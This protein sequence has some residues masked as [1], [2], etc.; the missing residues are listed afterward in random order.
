[1]VHLKSPEQIE[2]LRESSLLVGKTLAEVAK[3]M[4]PGVTTQ[5]LDSIAEEFIRDH[6]AVPGFKGY[7]GFPATLCVSVN[8][9]VV[10]GI[11]S[12]RVIKNGD[13]ISVDCGVIKNKYYGD[14][15]YTFPVGEVDENV[16][17]L[18]EVTKASLYEGIEAAIAGN[19]IGDIGYAIQSYV[20][21]H[22]FSVVRELV[23]HGLGK[24]LHEKPEVMNYGRRGNGMKLKEGLVICIEPMI[25]LGGRQVFQEADGWTVRT[26]D[27][28]PSAHYEHAIAVKKDKADILST[29]KYIEE[30]L[31][32]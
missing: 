2:L 5:K 31:N 24:K 17:K 10:H 27:R 4:K 20:E 32:K 16:K 28:M 15:A 21:M 22:S 6:D 7:K 11:P 25:N 8:E 13:I 30:V 18:M 9:Q 29:F 3:W 26:A 14:S 23:G 1:M 12:D 19:R